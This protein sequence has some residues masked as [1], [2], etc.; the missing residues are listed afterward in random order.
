M[1]AKQKGIQ[2][3]PQNKQFLYSLFTSQTTT[4]TYYSIRSDGYN[5]TV[6]KQGKLAFNPSDDKHGYLN[7]IQGLSWD[8]H[9]QKG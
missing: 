5:L 4:A 1:K 8:K 2:H 7:P 9:T 3:T 6:Q